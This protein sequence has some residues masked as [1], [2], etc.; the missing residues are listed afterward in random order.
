MVAHFFRRA[1]GLLRKGGALGLIATNTIAQG[2]TRSTGLRWIVTHGGVIYDATRRYKWPAGAAVIV[3]VVH[4]LR[5]SGTGITRRLDGDEV[6]RISAFLFHTGPDDDPVVLAANA[7][8][9]FQGSIVLGMGFTF[10]DTNR[11]ATSLAEMRRLIATNPRNQERIFPYLGGEE[12]NTSPTHAHHRYVINFGQMS[13]EEAR[14]WPELMSI[15]EQKAKPKRLTDN[16]ASYRKF[17]WH[18][19]EKRVDLYDAIRGLDRVVERNLGAEATLGKK[20]GTRK[21]ERSRKTSPKVGPD[22]FGEPD[23]GHA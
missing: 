14:K 16:R 9:S 20:G 8:K 18:F 6:E 5:G 19:A 11:E 10:D 3:S 23:G 21:G 7:N 13:E 12:L 17:W 15:V 2:D 22:L 1:F 4:I